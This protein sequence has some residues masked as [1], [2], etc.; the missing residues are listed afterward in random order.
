MGGCSHRKA[1]AVRRRTVRLVFGLIVGEK[2]ADWAA[3]DE[4]IVQKR[5]AAAS[6]ISADVRSEARPVTIV[7]VRD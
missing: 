1:I 2:V 4:P 7:G 5:D 6:P 3:V